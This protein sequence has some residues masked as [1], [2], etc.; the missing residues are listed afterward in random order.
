MAFTDINSEDRLVPKTLA[1]PLSEDEVQAAAKRVDEHVGQ[2]YAS[3]PF[4]SAAYS[5]SCAS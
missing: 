1:A 3:G 4:G 2:Q 5:R